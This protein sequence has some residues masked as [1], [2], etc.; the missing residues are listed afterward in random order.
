M[1][2]MPPRGDE[3][4]GQAENTRAPDRLRPQAM[5][6]TGA[7]IIASAANHNPIPLAKEP[8]DIQRGFVPGRHCTNDIEVD[9][10]SRFHSI[11]PPANSN[12]P[13]F[14]GM[15]IAAPFPSLLQLWH[16]NGI[17]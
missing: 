16:W 7:K 10:G 15:D 5:K 8:S 3:P 14:L 4:A 2:A 9:G 17:H 12:L 13:C 1:T 6:N 11:D